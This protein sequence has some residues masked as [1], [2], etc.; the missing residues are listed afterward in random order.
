MK[1]LVLFLA[2]GIAAHATPYV[3]NL[4]GS[5]NYASGASPFAVGDT[6]TA[7]FTIDTDATDS[8]PGDATDGIYLL[9]TPSLVQFS[10]GLTFAN[11]PFQYV[12]ADNYY[13]PYLNT[14]YDA[15]AFY[16]YQPTF[17]LGF[18]MRFDTGTFT[19]DLA[20]TPTLQTL[21]PQG[22]SQIPVPTNWFYFD[23]PAYSNSTGGRI[24]S[25]TGETQSV[26]DQVSVL[27]LLG[28]PAIAL[29]CLRRFRM[30]G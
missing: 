3:F 28:L 19:N 7:Q 8:A 26:P 5:A 15:V 20:I 18:E 16:F 13:H 25:I 29:A 2:L 27:G 10:N 17:L 30:T 1:T 14:T 21:V 9:S 12:V 6:F 4:S 23:L 22:N 24:S 11:I